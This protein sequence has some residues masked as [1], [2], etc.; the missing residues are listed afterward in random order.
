MGGIGG[1]M[2]QEDVLW[3]FGLAVLTAMPAGC[4]SESD[5]TPDA[6][7]SGGKAGTSAGQAGISG[8]RGGRAGSGATDRGGG[9]G[10][11]NSAG[12][13]AGKDDSSA[14]E[15]SEAG[16][17]SGGAAGMSGGEGGAGP[18]LVELPEG[19]RERA[20]VVN[21]VDADA[22]ADLAGYL[23]SEP[24]GIEKAVNLFLKYYVEQYDFVFVS[25]DHDMGTDLAGRFVHVTAPALAGT[26][27]VYD[28][29]AEGYTTSGRL[30]GAVGLNYRPGYF[31]PATHELAHNWGNFLNRKFGFS[32]QLGG[33]N[34]PHWGYAAFQGVLGGF[35][36]S[37]L[38]CAAPVDAV[39]PGCTAESNGRI[40]YRVRQFRPNGNYVNLAPLE[41]YLMGLSPASSLPETFSVLEEATTLEGSEDPSRNTIGVEARGIK[42]FPSADIIAEHGLVRELPAEERA[43]SAAFVVVSD[44][45]ASDE[46][47]DSIGQLAAVFGKRTDDPRGQ[48]F[49]AQTGGRATLDTRLGPRRA[50]ADPTPQL[51]VPSTCDIFDQD[52]GAGRSCYFRGTRGECGLTGAGERDDACE[53]DADCAE[54]LG[55][56]TNLTSQARACEPYCSASSS[57]ANACAT[58]CTNFYYLGDEDDRIVGGICQPP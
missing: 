33:D 1:A 36:G 41:L 4:S 38:R 7:G 55:C 28:F 18:E 53:T 45:P 30:R 3:I 58:L 54:G 20:G 31:P 57:A 43:F 21:L 34:G 15:S 29:E 44:K 27:R 5:S 16:A 2:K 49:E 37:S 19:S 48:S 56:A 46:V 50:V 10:T 40:R 42:T 47:L 39:P 51:R 26:G 14:G 12:G 22:A 9:S 11:A 13:A 32:A 24:V 25:S 52:C 23:G 6:Q 8:S 35:D 17:H